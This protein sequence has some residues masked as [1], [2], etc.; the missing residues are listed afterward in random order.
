VRVGRVKRYVNR[1]GRVLDVRRIQQERARATVLDAQVKARVAE[2]TQNQRASTYHAHEDLVGPVPYV[3]HRTD[4]GLYELRGLALLDARDRAVTARQQVQDRLVEWSEASQRVE[5]LERL[6]GRRRD[7]HRR[8]AE[9]E[10]EREVDDLVTGR[11]R[12]NEVG[13]RDRDDE[14]GDND[15]R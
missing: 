13:Q 4:R 2:I 14:G 10:A 6:D 9:R 15:E 3:H 1:L 8:D 5:N 11:F 7:E 12:R